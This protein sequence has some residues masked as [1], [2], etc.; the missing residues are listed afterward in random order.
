M[1]SVSFG[2][3]WFI[4]VRPWGRGVHLVFVGLIRARPGCRLEH[5]GALCVSLG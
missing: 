4:G 2:S 3:V 5:L 1:S